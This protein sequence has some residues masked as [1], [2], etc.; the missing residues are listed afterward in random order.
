MIVMDVSCFMYLLFFAVLAQ[1][2]TAT[3]RGIAKYLI[4]RIEGG[5]SGF[6]V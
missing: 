1:F 3:E 6:L 2:A 5:A 4:A